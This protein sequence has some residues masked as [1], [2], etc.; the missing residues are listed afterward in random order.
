MDFRI[1]T[2]AVEMYISDG[3]RTIIMLTAYHNSRK[4]DLL[5]LTKLIGPF[6]PVTKGAALYPLLPAFFNV[7]CR[8]HRSSPSSADAGKLER[9]CCKT[10]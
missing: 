10:A 1:S 4:T 5:A 7:L 9:I 6:E 3:R 2:F 8:E